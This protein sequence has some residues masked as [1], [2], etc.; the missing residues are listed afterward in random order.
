ML[1]LNLQLLLL[2]IFVGASTLKSAVPLSLTI[3][4]CIELI[5]HHKKSQKCTFV[6]KHAFC[7]L[8]VK[9]SVTL[10]TFP[11]LRKDFRRP[12][13]HRF[14]WKNNKKKHTTCKKREHNFI[15][16]FVHAHM[17]IVVCIHELCF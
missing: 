17:H 14:Q 4:L 13:T 8:S 5:K 1:L 10:K 15:I 6:T 12:V 7:V 11:S 16:V 9:F 2:V 3:L